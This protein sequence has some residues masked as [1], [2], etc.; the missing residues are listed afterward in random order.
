MS[1]ASEIV[2]GAW[3]RHLGEGFGAPPK[4]GELRSN[5]WASGMKDCGRA[6]ALDLIHPEDREPFDAD[7]MERMQRGRERD[8][9]VSVRLSE[10]GAFASHRFDLERRQE[11]FEIHDRR[12]GG[13]LGP[14]IVTG[15]V[16]GVVSWDR[17]VEFEHSGNIHVVKIVPLEIKSGQAAMRCQTIEDV[18]TGVWTKHFLD[19]TL[20]Y[21]YAANQKGAEV[22]LGLLA[23][24]QSGV[25]LLL[26][27]WLEDHLERV[28]EILT[29]ARAAWNVRHK[30]ADL[31]P[32]T[33]DPTVCW[34]CDHF[35]KSCAPTTDYGPGVRLVDDPEMIE[36]LDRRGEIKPM[37]AEYTKLHGIIKKRFANLDVD[38]PVA[39]GDWTLVKKKQKNGAVLKI[40]RIGGGDE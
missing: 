38:Q 36:M 14:I 4:P 24:E 40:E 27:V 6:L 37:S 33:K 9:A 23:L 12:E 13:E 29:M 2:S 7:S 26:E 20:M 34:R 19:Q 18:L 16:D 32:E 11:R 15:K 10:S 22:P 1:S 3:V 25:P 30:D 8:R 28:E 31:P 39:A 21:I 17:P 35:R 5:V